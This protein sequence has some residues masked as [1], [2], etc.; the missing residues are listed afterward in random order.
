MEE[1]KKVKNDFLMRTFLEYDVFR[2]GYYRFGF[3]EPMKA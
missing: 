1:H 3:F 2:G